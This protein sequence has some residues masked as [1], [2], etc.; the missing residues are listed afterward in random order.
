[1]RFIAFDEEERTTPQRVESTV[2]RG[3]S[4]AGHHV[5]PLVAAAVAV[6]R[7]AFSVARLD[8]HFSR[9]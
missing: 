9:L 5:E 3:S 6:L 4:R 8:G 1:M 7:I 2:N